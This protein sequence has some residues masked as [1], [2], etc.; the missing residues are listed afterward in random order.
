MGVADRTVPDR[1]KRRRRAKP[2]RRRGAKDGWKD[3][4]WVTIL[5]VPGLVIACCAGPYFG[6]ET[7]PATAVGAL[8]GIATPLYK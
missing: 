8:A 7:T 4:D 5:V 1:A 3:L 6:S 2:A